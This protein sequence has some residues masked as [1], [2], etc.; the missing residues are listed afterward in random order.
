M[1]HKSCYMW[2]YLTNNK[3]P[4]FHMISKFLRTYGL[5]GDSVKLGCTEQSGEWAK[6]KEFCNVEEKYGYKIEITG[7]DNLSKNWQG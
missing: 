4:T 5:H 2:I 1:D 7:T 3:T 6:S